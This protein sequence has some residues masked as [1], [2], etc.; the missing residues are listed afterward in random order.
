MIR[1]VSTIHTICAGKADVD[2]EQTHV[3]EQNDRKFMIDGG[4]R[5][6]PPGPPLRLAMLWVLPFRRVPMEE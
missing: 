6:C 3:V 2:F 4:D 5:A 1:L